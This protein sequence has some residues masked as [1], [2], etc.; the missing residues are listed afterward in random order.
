MGAAKGLLGFGT[1]GRLDTC[2]NRV[3]LCRPGSEQVGTRRDDE[4]EDEKRMQWHRDDDHRDHGCGEALHPD[5]AL[6]HLNDPQLPSHSDLQGNPP[7]SRHRNP[8]IPR[9]VLTALPHQRRLVFP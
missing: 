6:D 5:S 8:T 2:G 7:T 9:P 1:T 3:Y 4:H